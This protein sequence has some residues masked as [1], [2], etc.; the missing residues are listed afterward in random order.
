MLANKQ[1]KHLKLCMIL[2]LGFMGF[3]VAKPI[4]AQA[5]TLYWPVP[6]HTRLSQG[7]HNGNAI[8]ISDSSIAGANVVAAMGG[9]V[10]H[11]YLCGTQHL[12]KTCSCNGFGNGLVIAGDDGRIYQ[13]AHMQAGSIPANVYRTAYV[14]AGQQIGKVGTTG[15]SSGNHLHFGISKGNYWNASGINPANE[16]YNYGNSSGSSSTAD[17]GFSSVSVSNITNNDA[18][19][20]ATIP[21]K[22]VNECGYFIGTDPNNLVLGGQDWPNGYVEKIFYNTIATDSS[23]T[24]G[25]LQPG[26]TYYYYFYYKT[27]NAYFETQRR[28]FTTTGSKEVTVSFNANG[29]SVSTASKKTSSNKISSYPTPTRKNYKFLGWY[30]SSDTKVTTSTVFKSNTT[31]IARWQALPVSLQVTKIKKTYYVDDELDVDDITIKVVYADGSHK[32]LG[33]NQEEIKNSVNMSFAHKQRLTFNY[34]EEGVSLTGYVEF[35]IL[36][37]PE[38]S[39]WEEGIKDDPVVEP[40]TEESDEE[41]G[42]QTQESNVEKPN[43]Q[44]TSKNVTIPTVDK[45]KKFKAKSVRKGLTLTWKKVSGVDGYQIQVSTKKN[46]KNSSK[47][48]VSGNKVKYKVTKLKAKKKYYVRIRAYKTYEGSDGTT[49]KVYGKYV[50]LNK[51]TK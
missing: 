23:S 36:E 20:T 9:K 5:A 30:N 39:K 1:R 3:V 46:F 47:Y 26:T 14:Y 19:I 29:G 18:T 15:N 16:T 31:L 8:D 45:V 22:T 38:D 6:G 42:E 48:N 24:Y 28:T 21:G 2:L 13:Y 41:V 25:Y 32:A 43:P 37:K 49:K 51:R 12:G 33:Y 34:D 11:I 40:E 27:Q 7:Y 17:N 44:T 4:Q 50:S 35:D 10:T